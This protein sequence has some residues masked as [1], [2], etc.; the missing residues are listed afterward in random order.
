MIKNF[1]QYL[2]WIKYIDVLSHH[3]IASWWDD[4]LKMRW[5]INFRG[6]KRAVQSLP[7]P[8]CTTEITSTDF[9]LFL[10]LYCFDHFDYFDRSEVT[11]YSRCCS[12]R[13]LHNFNT[14]LEI[15]SC[16]CRI[17]H[18]DLL[19]RVFY[20]LFDRDRR[21]DSYS[22]SHSAMRQ[23]RFDQ[24]DCRIEIDVA[25]CFRSNTIS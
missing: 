19:C 21:L 23:R 14:S 11:F 8:H 16:R 2:I 1:I 24:F 17:Y 12:D 25:W 10:S 6:C 9:E 5:W 3:L 7:L 15:D 13:V 20:N 4:N 18:H 22:E